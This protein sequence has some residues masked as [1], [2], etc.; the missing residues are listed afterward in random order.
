METIILLSAFMSFM[1]ENVEWLLIS[2]G[3]IST[4]KYASH[5]LVFKAEWYSIVS[6]FLYLVIISQRTFWLLLTLPFVNDVTVNIICGNK[7]V[8]FNKLLCM[9][10]CIVCLWIWVCRTENNLRCHFSSAFL[11]FVWD[12]ISY[13]PGTHQVGQ[14]GWCV[15]SRDL[16]V[17]A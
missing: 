5:F 10:M 6:Y 15:S 7:K 4:L 17:S 16:P 12:T 14:A 1:T 11:L 3:L 2:L 9:H 13:W 8:A